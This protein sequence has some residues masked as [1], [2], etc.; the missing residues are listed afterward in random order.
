MAYLVMFSLYV[1]QLNTTGRS[2]VIGFHCTEDAVRLYPDCPIL[3]QEQ[4]AQ[5]NNNPYLLWAKWTIALNQVLLFASW[6]GVNR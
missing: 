1:E 2:I 4:L 5:A 6:V 3:S